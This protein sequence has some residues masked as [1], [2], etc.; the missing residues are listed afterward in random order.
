MMAWHCGDSDVSMELQKSTFSE[1]GSKDR[2]IPLTMG[3]M[4][5][6]KDR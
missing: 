4:G 6:L 3:D 1:P 5:C 2:K